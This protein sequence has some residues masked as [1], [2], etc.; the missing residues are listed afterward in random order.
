MRGVLDKKIDDN[1]ICQD[2]MMQHCLLPKSQQDATN[3]KNRQIPLPIW[4]CPCT[5]LFR[6][7]RNTKVDIAVKVTEAGSEAATHP[8]SL[9][10]A[11]LS[12]FVGHIADQIG[13]RTVRQ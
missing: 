9:N 7:Y 1:P 12:A 13:M 11:I 3:W 6:V 4:A 10:A 5:N 2:E 8:N